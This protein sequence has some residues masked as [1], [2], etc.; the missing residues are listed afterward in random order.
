M[1]ANYIHRSLCYSWLVVVAAVGCW[2]QR[3][4]PVQSDNVAHQDTTDLQTDQKVRDWLREMP[5][6]PLGEPPRDDLGELES[7]WIER[8]RQIPSVEGALIRILRDKFSFHRRAAAFVIGRVGSA[9][10]LDALATLFETDDVGLQLDAVGSIRAIKS[11]RRVDVLSVALESTY[12][13]PE[14]PD[15]GV[16]TAKAIVRA[17]IAIA[18]SEIDDRGAERLLT[19]VIAKEQDPYVLDALKPRRKSGE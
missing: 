10:A 11:P 18:L 3:S 14:Q 2:N 19:S 9:K 16:P 13:Q 1:N 7:A 12:R 4:V 6:Q 5:R 15:N 17:N 8:G